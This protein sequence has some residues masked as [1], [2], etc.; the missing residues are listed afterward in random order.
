MNTQLT[1]EQRK[2][3]VETAVK[4]AG[5]TVAGI[6]F[7]PVALLAVGGLIGIIIAGT[8]SLS[9]IYATPVVAMKLANWRLKMLKAEATKNPV[10]TLQNQYVQKEAALQQLKENI[11]TFTAQVLFADTF[12]QTDF[13]A[14]LAIC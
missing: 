9:I 10:E 2:K 14:V 3:R 6:L 4:V 11:R 7:A 12:F 8:I 5:L 13:Y 1:P